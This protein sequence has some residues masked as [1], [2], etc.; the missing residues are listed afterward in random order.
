MELCRDEV[1]EKEGTE[2]FTNADNWGGLWQIS[3]ETYGVVENYNKSI[4]S[5]EEFD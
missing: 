4:F 2:L 1:D 5:S 3:N